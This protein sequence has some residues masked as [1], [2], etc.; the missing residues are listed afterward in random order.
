MLYYYVA[1]E[2]VFDKDGR[3]TGEKT[4]C[5]SQDFDSE[6]VC[7]HFGTQYQRNHSCFIEYHTK[8][9]A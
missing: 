3:K 7:R 4:V 9:E 8:K 5:V 1:K 2:N 6:S